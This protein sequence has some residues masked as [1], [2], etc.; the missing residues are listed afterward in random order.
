MA[1]DLLTRE[2]LS[3]L[4]AEDPY[5]GRHPTVPLDPG[6]GAPLFSPADFSTLQEVLESYL[7]PGV[8]AWSVLFGQSV[9]L[10]QP[11]ISLVS[12]EVL[13]QDPTAVVEIEFLQGL[14]GR[15]RFVMPLAGAC[16]LA[17]FALGTQDTPTQ[18]DAI[19]RSS[20]VSV[21]KYLLAEM[22]TLLMRGSGRRSATSDPTV[23]LWPEEIKLPAERLVQARIPWSVEG[24]PE[25]NLLFWSD[26]T[27]TRSLLSLA[28]PRPRLVVPDERSAPASLK[29]GREAAGRSREPLRRANAEEPNRLAITSSRNSEGPESACSKEPPR[30]GAADLVVS[31]ENQASSSPS[32]EHQ[33]RRDPTMK[34]GQ[35]NPLALQAEKQAATVPESSSLTSLARPESTRAPELSLAHLGEEVEIRVELGRGLVHEPLKL[36]QVVPLDRIAGESADIFAGDDLMARGEVTASEETLAVRI[37]HIVLGRRSSPKPQSPASG[38]RTS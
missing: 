33:A 30:A 38:G 2:E 29:P 24:Q 37:T 3:L 28:G 34:S 17:G 13:G 26:L 36:G 9:N 23:L 5:Q 15:A 21:M 19:H 27:L 6:V 20:L 14:K 32:D 18:F 1:K 35:R 8:V 22:R 10:G 31:R 4:L 11:E 16:K 25:E 7:V 12:P